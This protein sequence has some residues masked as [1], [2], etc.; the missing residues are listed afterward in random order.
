M[1]NKP[2][3]TAAP[4]TAIDMKRTH[5]S[6]TITRMAGFLLLG[7]CSCIALLRPPRTVEVQVLHMSMDGQ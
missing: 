5:L 2:N 6:T 7:N 1:R 3:N 4:L